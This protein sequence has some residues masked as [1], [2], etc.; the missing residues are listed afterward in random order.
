[1][2]CWRWFGAVLKEAGLEITDDNREKIDE[3]IHKYVGEQSSYGRCSTDWKK[4]R[5]EVKADEKMRQEL[6]GK[7]QSN[8]INRMLMLLKAVR[9]CEI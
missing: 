5:K 4:A 1:L 6:C 8:C 3:V 7:A 2:G 9:F